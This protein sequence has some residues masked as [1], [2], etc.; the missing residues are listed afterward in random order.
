MTV[1]SRRLKQ[2]FED[3]PG[4]QEPPKFV[5]YRTLNS[6]CV[7]GRQ[8]YLRLSDQGT[9]LYVTR[10]ALIGAQVVRLR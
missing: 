3:V 10:S 7:I 4:V 8:K 2:G 6:T 1:C 5:W 9:N